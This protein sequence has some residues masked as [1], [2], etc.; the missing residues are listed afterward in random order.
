MANARRTIASRVGEAKWGPGYRAVTQAT[1]PNDVK[2]E[3]L[4]LSQYLQ[5]MKQELAAIRNPKVERDHFASMSDQ[6]DAVV[7]ATE[8]ATETMT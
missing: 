8:S 1:L 5:T 2:H 4:L 6:L 7:G 3:L